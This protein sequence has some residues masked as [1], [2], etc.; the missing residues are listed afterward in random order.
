MATLAFSGKVHEVIH[1]LKAFEIGFDRK[2]DAKM[3]SFIGILSIPG[4]LFVPKYFI[5]E[6]TLSGVSLSIK[7]DEVSIWVLVS[8]FCQIL[9][10]LG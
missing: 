1:L 4:A 6:F 7:E 2:S 5:A 3:I 8:A 10:I 9:T